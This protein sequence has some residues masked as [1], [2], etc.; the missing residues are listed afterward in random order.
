MKRKTRKH[1]D[2]NTHKCYK[3]AKRATTYKTHMKTTKSKKYQSIYGST[4]D[5]IIR[6]VRQLYI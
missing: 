4:S 6:T 3:Y 1:C 5:F 2:R